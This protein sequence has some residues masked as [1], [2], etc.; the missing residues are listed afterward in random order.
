M[1]YKLND[2][3]KDAH[4]MMKNAIKKPVTLKASDF[5]PGAL[6]LF[7]YRAKYDKNPYDASPIVLV[8]ARNRTHTVGINWNWVH[9]GLRKG[10]MS[11]IIKFNRKNIEKGLPFDV[12][13]TLVK[14]IFRMGLPAF[15]KYINKRISPKG[16]IVP[17]NEYVKV[18][19][20]RAEHFIGIS[21]EQAWKIALKTLKKNKR[22]Y[23][24]SKSTKKA[25]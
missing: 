9:P 24:K 2:L 7:T 1:A 17:Q 14:Q 4:L 23:K 19:H 20:L 12:P 11:L 22:V 5:K 15:R 16:V 8:L 25:K 10:L 13:P 6:I 18:V 21:S 3:E